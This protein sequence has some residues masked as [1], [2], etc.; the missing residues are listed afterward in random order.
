MDEARMLLSELGLGGGFS[1]GLPLFA[2][3]EPPG[4][5]TMRGETTERGSVLGT[6]FSSLFCCCSRSSNGCCVRPV[7][8][9]RHCAAKFAS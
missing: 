9:A 7:R 3:H 1:P 2:Y 6:L 4:D 5:E 8:A